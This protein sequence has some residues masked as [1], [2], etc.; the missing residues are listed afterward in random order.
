MERVI[1][2]AVFLVLLSCHAAGGGN[3]WPPPSLARHLSSSLSARQVTAAGGSGSAVPSTV[4][5]ETQQYTQ[6]LDHFNVAPASYGTFQQRYLV[7]DTFWGGKTAP[8][9]LYAGNEGDVELFANNTGFMWEVAPRFRAMLV[10]VEV[11]Y[12]YV[13]VIIKY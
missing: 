2:A 3:R 10:F 1:S 11:A 7:N 8:I 9:F 5:Y 12:A 4:Q 13:H 6:R